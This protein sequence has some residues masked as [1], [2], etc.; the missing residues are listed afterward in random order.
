M[1]PIAPTKPQTMLHWAMV[2]SQEPPIVLL[3][4]GTLFVPQE[5]I[6][7][8]L[9]HRTQSWENLVSQDSSL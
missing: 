9:V 8:R 4:F 1:L 3:N 5:A 2:D 7:A 6:L